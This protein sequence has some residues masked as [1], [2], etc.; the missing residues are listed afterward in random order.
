M[1]ILNENQL[2]MLERF[3]SAVQEK[4]EFGF[5]D[6]RLDKIYQ[7]AEGSGRGWRGINEEDPTHITEAFNLAQSHWKEVMQD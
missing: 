4:K 7:F 2:S 3:S 6:R 5:L 1:A